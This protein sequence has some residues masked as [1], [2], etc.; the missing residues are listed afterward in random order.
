MPPIDPTDLNK[1]K[2]LI[3]WYGWRSWQDIRISRSIESLR[4]KAV[5]QPAVPP[6]TT[7]KCAGLPTGCPLS[8]Q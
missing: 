3:G 5:I 4:I 8:P 7:T 2:L 6:P 1:V